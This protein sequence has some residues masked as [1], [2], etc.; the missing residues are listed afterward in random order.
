MET[1][2][3]RLPVVGKQFGKAILGMAADAFEDIA[4]VREGIDA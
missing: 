1:R 2:R 3:F 4:Q